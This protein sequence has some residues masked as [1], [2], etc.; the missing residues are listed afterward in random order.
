MCLYEVHFTDGRA[1]RINADACW[2][3]DWSVVF[4]NIEVR[5]SKSTGARAGDTVERLHTFRIISGRE[6]KEVREIAR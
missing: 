5:P 2:A 4:A 6:V 3:N 1:E